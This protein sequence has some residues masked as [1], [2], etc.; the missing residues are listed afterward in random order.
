MGYNFLSFLH[1]AGLFA[2]FFL[3]LAFLLTFTLLVD[4]LPFEHWKKK[5]ENESRAILVVSTLF[6]FKLGRLFYSQLRS[7]PWFNAAS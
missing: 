4:D 5:Y 3:N 2:L 7:R 6:T 1:L